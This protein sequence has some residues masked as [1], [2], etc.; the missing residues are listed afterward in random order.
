MLA[1]A[2]ACAAVVELR[3]VQGDYVDGSAGQKDIQSGCTECREFEVPLP[4]GRVL[5]LEAS[6]SPDLA[7][8]FS[9][10]RAVLIFKNGRPGTEQ[11]TGGG[12]EKAAYRVRLFVDRKNS[13]AIT[14]LSERQM[15]SGILVSIDGRATARTWVD[16]WSPWELDA[17]SFD[18][19]EEVRKLFAGGPEP[20]VL[21]IRTPGSTEAAVD[22]ERAKQETRWRLACDPKFREIVRQEEEKRRGEPVA[23]IEQPKG[24]DC[25]ARPL[26]P[27]G[28]TSHT[29]ETLRVQG[30]VQD[31]TRDGI[32][33]YLNEHGEL[34]KIEVYDHGSL[35][36]TALPTLGR[37]AQRLKS[38]LQKE[39]QDRKT[40]TP[41]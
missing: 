38:I 26:E 16:A 34:A 17:G 40:V 41:P 15:R 4:S 29:Q 6:R 25:T 21:P 10:I 27:A 8:S 31:G 13:E 33:V 35:V 12:A 11:G 36:Q 23:E 24:V 37:D 18:S 30:V 39:R 14:R 32:W 9:S 2:D 3:L 1:V 7:I 5:H 20:V 19:V 28:E 22:I